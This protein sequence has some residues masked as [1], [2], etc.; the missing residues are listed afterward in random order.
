M[1][2]AYI[3]VDVRYGYVNCCRKQVDLCENAG[4][5]NLSCPVQQ[6]GISVMKEFDLPKAIPPVSTQYIYIYTGLAIN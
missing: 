4:E 5:I 1:E 3:S 2:D 6:G